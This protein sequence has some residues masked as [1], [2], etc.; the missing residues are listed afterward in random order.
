[1]EK[2]VK[3]MELEW[4][5]LKRKMILSELIIYWGIL[6]FLPMFFIKMVSAEFGQSYSTIIQLMMSMQLGFVLFG[7]SLI[8]QVVI[9]EYKNK[10]ISL[11]FGY[12]IS[13]K[14]LVMAKALFIS[15]FVFLCTI[16]SFLL[17]GVTTYLLDQAFHII[18][19]QPTAEDITSYF[20]K[21]IVHSLIVTL[22]SLIPLFFFGIWKRETIPTI[23]CAIFLMQFQNFSFLLNVNLNTNIVNTV[24]CSLGVV[25]VYLSI[26]MVDRVGDI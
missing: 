24:L 23:L 12:P 10:T 26:K 16:V 18:N 2:L 20:S 8:N 14:K 5:K 17:S 25:S 22:I 9:D 15:L 13:R 7:A 1:M 11:S 6:M 21:M 3:L 19:G 4:R